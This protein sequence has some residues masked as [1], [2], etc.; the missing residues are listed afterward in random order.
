MSE[1]N[2]ENVEFVLEKIRPYLKIDGGNVELVKIKKD[3]GIVEVCLTG[4]CK[5][6]PLRMMTLRAGIERALMKEIPD[7]K[8]IE[9]VV[10]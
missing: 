5:E 3:E 9:S 7:V 1:L 2:I 10:M 6:C 8:R 4:A